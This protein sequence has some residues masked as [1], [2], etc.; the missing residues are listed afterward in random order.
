METIYAV[1]EWVY[2]GL[3]L[4][5]SLFQSLIL[6]SATGQHCTTEVGLLEQ[7]GRWLFWLIIV[8]VCKL[9]FFSAWHILLNRKK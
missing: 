1:M 7:E 3:F 5:V 9:T 8:Q 6:A 2:R 4:L